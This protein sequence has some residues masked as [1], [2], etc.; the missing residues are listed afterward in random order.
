MF[1]VLCAVLCEPQ[2]ELCEAD[3]FQSR[4]EAAEDEDAGRDEDASGE[5]RAAGLWPE[6]L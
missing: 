3:A 1:W 6:G 2:C 5:A 4:V